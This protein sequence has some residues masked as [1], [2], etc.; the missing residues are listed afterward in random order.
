VQADDF[1]TPPRMDP[2]IRTGLFAPFTVLALVTAVVLVIVFAR[3]RSATTAKGRPGATPQ[4]AV[5]KEADAEQLV[6]KLMETESDRR[7]T[8]GALGVALFVLLL[9]LGL[10]YLVL[11]FGVGVWIVRDAHNRGHEG[12]LWTMIF[13]APHGTLAVWPTLSLVGFLSWALLIVFLFPLSW[14][15]LPFYLLS[16]RRG[17]LMLCEACGNQRLGYA[18][19]WSHGRSLRPETALLPIWSWDQFAARLAGA[20]APFASPPPNSQFRTCSV[21]AFRRSSLMVSR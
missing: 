15:G 1:E 2:R 14:I 5:A 19:E 6:R 17:V 20:C 13:F 16:R 8:G 7:Q 12:A 9:V 18:K 4:P 10:A 11:V 3:S 21:T